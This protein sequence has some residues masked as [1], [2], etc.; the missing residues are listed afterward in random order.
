L[1]TLDL[2]VAWHPGYE[3]DAAHRW[4]RQCVRDAF[5]VN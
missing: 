2:S 5:V 3:A 4:L 1:P